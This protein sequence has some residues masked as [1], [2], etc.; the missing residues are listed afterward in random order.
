MQFSGSYQ[1]DVVFDVF[2]QKRLFSIICHFTVLVLLFKKIITV[3]VVPLLYASGFACF[4][5]LVQLTN[6]Q[7]GFH[8]QELIATVG[9]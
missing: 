5:K 3:T 2:F 1:T 6:S 7:T 8:F 9:F 4:G